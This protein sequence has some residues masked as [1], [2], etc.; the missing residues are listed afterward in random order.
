MNNRVKN[1]QTE[2]N[3][4]K[5]S[6]KGIKSTIKFFLSREEARVSNYNLFVDSIYK[7][8]IQF[9]LKAQYTRVYGIQIF[10]VIF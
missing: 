3:L 8:H 10:L 7:V 1:V 5:Q 4:L 6:V 2:I 9:V